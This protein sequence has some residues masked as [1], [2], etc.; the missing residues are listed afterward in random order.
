M[1]QRKKDKPPVDDLA[2]AGVIIFED[3]GSVD[4][5]LEASG[6]PLTGSRPATP[7]GDVFDRLVEAGVVTSRALRKARKTQKDNPRESLQSVLLRQGACS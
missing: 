7:K 4:D 5:L 6:V 3:P 1:A 2:E